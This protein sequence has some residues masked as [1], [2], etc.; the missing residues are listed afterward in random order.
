MCVVLAGC[1][2]TTI[3]LHDARPSSNALAQASR[4]AP[5][6]PAEHPT[7]NGS[8]DS[9][10]ARRSI[11]KA[12]ASVVDEATPAEVVQTSAEDIV[13]APVP[14]A[15][16]ESPSQRLSIFQAVET[17]LSL[18]PDLQ[19]QRQAEPV[20]E[21]VLG[22]A[23]TYPFNPFVQ[24]QATPFQHQKDAG[25]GAVYHYVLLMQQIQLAHQQDFREENAGALLNSTRWTVLQAQLLCVAQ[26]E[27]LYFTA[28]YQR[29]LRDLAKVNAQNNQDVLTTL[30]RQLE[31]G[32]ATAADVAMVRL[33]ARATQRQLQLA[34]ANY[35]T[36]LLDLKRQ[37]G[38]PIS[39][40]SNW[41]AT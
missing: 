34:E 5:P 28:L 32:Q 7:R 38:L 41:T 25:P 10:A 15:P 23:Q 18:N 24:V 17:A 13:P 27:R 39:P 29:G 14:P 35:Q 20:A 4:R 12:S 33:D 3:A 6:S 40:R 11:A 8:A 22:V 16:G 37:I 31:A 2:T 36:A 26:T 1:R 19:A 9:I 30:E 21:G